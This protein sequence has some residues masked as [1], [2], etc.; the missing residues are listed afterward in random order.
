MTG[1]EWHAEQDRLAARCAWWGNVPWAR[2][3]GF[4][5]APP[6]P[7]WQ[8]AQ[9]RGFTTGWWQELQLSVDVRVIPP[10]LEKGV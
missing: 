7:S 5:G 1:G 10:C 6:G 8:V 3:M 4:E 9:F 2:R